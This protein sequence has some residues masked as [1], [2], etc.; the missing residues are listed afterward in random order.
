MGTHGGV[1]RFLALLFEASKGLENRVAGR[2]VGSRS[3]EKELPCGLEQHCLQVDVYFRSGDYECLSYGWLWPQDG[4][5][6]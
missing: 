6:F 1:S 4:L 3:A 5:C 2:G